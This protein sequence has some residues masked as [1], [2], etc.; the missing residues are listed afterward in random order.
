MPGIPGDFI[1]VSGKS[2]NSVTELNVDS[3]AV[4]P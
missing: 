2:S 3:G 4:P 1:W